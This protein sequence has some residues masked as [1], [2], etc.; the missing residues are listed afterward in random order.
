LL[1]EERNIFSPLEEKHEESL[2]FFLGK[3]DAFFKKKSQKKKRKESKKN[4]KL[5]Q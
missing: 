4:Q 3:H 5:F 2:T 1:E